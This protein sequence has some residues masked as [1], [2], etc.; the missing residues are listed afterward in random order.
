MI[1]FP[2][3]YNLLKKTIIL[4]RMY[5]SNCSSCSR[6]HMFP[7]CK[8]RLCVCGVC[9]HCHIGGIFKSHWF[10]KAKYKY[11][12]ICRDQSKLVPSIEKCESHGGGDC[13]FIP[14]CDHCTWRK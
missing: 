6:R 14:D 4:K 5:C 2:P 10:T 9:N 8:F 3:K 12:K 11:G 13:E 7:K 1:L